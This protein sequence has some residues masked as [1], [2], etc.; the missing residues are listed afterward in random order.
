MTNWTKSDRAPWSRDLSAG[1]RVSDDQAK[2]IC[3]TRLAD[4]GLELHCSNFWV[5]DA[6]KRR[7]IVREIRYRYNGGYVLNPALEG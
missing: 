2:V 5:D 4:F 3:T 6:S 7:W 1:D